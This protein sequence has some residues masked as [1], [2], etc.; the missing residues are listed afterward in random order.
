LKKQKVLVID[1][2]PDTVEII[3]VV[4]QEEIHLDVIG[5]ENMPD[6]SHLK[7]IS[8]DLLILDELLNHTRGSE[9]CTQVK[10]NDS[11]AGIPVLLIS[12]LYNI[13]KIAADCNADGFIQK[14][15]DIDDLAT[16]VI[17]TLG[18]NSQL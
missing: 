11:T 18:K 15:F 13:E 7:S 4:L 8:P 17:N 6:I 9:I 2:D 1:N 5:L 12:A 16:V 10:A 3:S 14:P